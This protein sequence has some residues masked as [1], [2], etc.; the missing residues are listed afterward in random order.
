MLQGP[1]ER[2]QD[3]DISVDVH[4]LKQK[5]H[6]AL[7]PFCT[8]TSS[9]DIS[10]TSEACAPGD[11]SHQ[12]VKVPAICIVHQ[13]MNT[14]CELRPLIDSKMYRAC[15]PEQPGHAAQHVPWTGAAGVLPAEPVW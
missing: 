11:P 5:P 12:L 4:Y 10:C 9:R 3:F 8:T 1:A 7:Y 13:F 14:F 6:A 15:L 2:N